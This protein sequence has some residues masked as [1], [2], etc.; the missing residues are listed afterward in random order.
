MRIAVGSK[1][2]VK[3]AAVK[4]GFEQMMPG[5]EFDVVGYDVDSGVNHQPLTDDETVLGATNRAKAALAADDMAA[6]GVGVEGGMDKRQY[7]WTEAQWVVVISRAGV[8]G[9]G[10]SLRLPIPDGFMTEVLAGKELGEVIDAHFNKT[11]MKQSGGYVGEVTNGL[12]GREDMA[13]SAVISALVPITNPE[14]FP[15]S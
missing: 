3:V 2:P 5:I 9:I 7:G 12:V 8:K 4:R 13:L 10:Q 1:N 6:F 14:L 11:N 15:K